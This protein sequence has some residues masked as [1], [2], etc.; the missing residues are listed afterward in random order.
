LRWDCDEVTTARL[1]VAGS[2]IVDT[3]LRDWFDGKID[4]EIVWV[5]ASVAWSF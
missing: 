1:A 2:T 3:E 5:T 4:P